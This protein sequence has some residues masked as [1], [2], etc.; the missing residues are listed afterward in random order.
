MKFLFSRFPTKKHI[1]DWRYLAV[2]LVLVILGTS[3][4]GCIDDKFQA[5][6]WSGPV[7]AD[8][9]LFICSKQGKLVAMDPANRNQLWAFAPDEGNGG[10]SMLF[11]CQGNAAPAL[12]VYGTPE[13]FNELIYIGAYNGKIYARDATNGQNRWTYSI[14]G[15]II[16]SIAINENN[17]TMIVGSSNGKLYALDA[18]KGALLWNEP[19]GVDGE[20]WSTPVIS[21]GT[22]YFGTLNHRLYAV[23]LE[24][25]SIKWEKELEGAIA[26][27]PLIAEGT[28]YI[29]TFG[30][31]FYAVDAATGEIKWQFSEAK[32]WFWTKAALQDG[33]V[34]AGSL[35]HNIYALDASTG[36][37]K[38]VQKT[39]GAIRSATVVV[40]NTV[41]VASDDG[42]VYGLD[43]ETGS[44]KWAPRDLDTSILAHPWVEDN[45][46]YFFDQNGT[47]Y[48]LE[49]KD[50]H[51]LWEKT[52]E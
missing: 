45:T 41:I 9:T 21:D 8:S 26:S 30:S 23:D 1:I 37:K 38:W 31:K 39:N 47:L 12:T 7:V 51:H 20:I 40:E 27:T 49:A 3:L 2:G 24:T 50:G 6:S 36:Q 52:F 5:K 4:T 25:K 10:G 16:G 15:N 44:E 13:V 18:E 29:G 19:L 35:D 22:V 33:V 48:A 42:K 11:G 46:I 28:V 34:Y 14:D 43:T 32:N 17:G